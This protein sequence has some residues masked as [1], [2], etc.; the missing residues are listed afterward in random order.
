MPVNV[1]FMFEGEEE[2]GSPSLE[3]FIQAH[4]DLL[5]ADFALSADG[6][7][8]RIDEPLGHD[9]QSRAG[10]AGIY[11]DRGG[12]DLHSGRHGGAVA[13]PLHAI[14][15]LVASLHAPDG[16]VAVTG[17]LRRCGRAAAG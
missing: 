12:K 17:L 7:M 8:W 11:A 16:R 9:F 13:N 3:P 1:K 15:E 6:G 10:R 5:A 4:T 2:I 14:A